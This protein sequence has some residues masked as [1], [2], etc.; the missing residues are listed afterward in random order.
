MDA[1]E[2]CGG[3]FERE[4]GHSGR[5]CSRACYEW[6]GPFRVKHIGSRWFIVNRHGDAERIGYVERDGVRAACDLLNGFIAHQRQRLAHGES[7]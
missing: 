5:F 4:R 1:C 7:E 3:S 6:R 2:R